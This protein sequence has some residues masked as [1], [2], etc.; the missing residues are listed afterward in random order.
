MVDTNVGVPVEEELVQNYFANLVNQFFKILPI[1][2]SGESTLPTY[3]RS[4]QVEILGCRG[5]IR[6]LDSNPMFMTLLSILEYLLE[7]PDCEIQEV[8]REVFKAIS[9]CNKLKRLDMSTDA[10]EGAE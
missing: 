6:P 8:K 9:I 5:F 1:R 4:L 2:E 10:R 7:N 3:I